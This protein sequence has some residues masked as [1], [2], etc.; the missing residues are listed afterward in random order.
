MVYDDNNN[1][2]Q[3]VQVGASYHVYIGKWRDGK[4]KINNSYIV[5]SVLGIY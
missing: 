4:Q 1:C 5:V 2:L 3:C